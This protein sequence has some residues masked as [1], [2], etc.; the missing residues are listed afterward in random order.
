MRSYCSQT[1]D[2]SVWAA[3]NKYR[4]NY[5]H[6]LSEEILNAAKKKA[7]NHGL[8]KVKQKPQNVFNQLCGMTC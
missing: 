3:Y 5:L 8:H 6:L 2:D 1:F 4:H 7:N